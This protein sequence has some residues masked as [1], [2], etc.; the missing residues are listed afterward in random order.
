[1]AVASVQTQS[2]CT[3]SLHCQTEK[4]KRKLVSTQYTKAKSKRNELQKEFLDK[5]FQDSLSQF[6]SRTGQLRDFLNLTKGLLDERVD[7]NN[8]AWQTVLHLG[9]YAACS[10][11]TG[12][13]YNDEYVEFLAL[14]NMLY[15]SSVLN[16][17]RGPGHFGT[18]ISGECEKGKFNPSTS[19]C[20]F[21]V[22]SHNVIQKRCEGY[23]KKIDPGIIES[24]LDICQE[25]ST[26]HG[27]QYN[28]SFD[29]MLIAQGSKGI[30]DGDVNL[31]GIKKPVSISKSQ[32]HLDLELKL[33][34]EL[35]IRITENN[36]G[37]QRY[38]IKRLLF[39]FMKRL[40][41]M[42]TRLTG[43]FLIEQ[44]MEK[45]KE[46]NPD[47]KDAFEHMLSL[48]F[49]NTTQIEN[50]VSRT[51]ATNM[52]ICHL[53][54]EMRGSKCCVNDTK[55]VKLH[56]QPNY[57]GLL[58]SEYVSKHIDLWKRENTSTVCS[59]VIYGGNLEEQP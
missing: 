50:C 32:K 40:Q 55:F 10:S 42:R 5:K 25:L 16:I 14:L 38:K 47:H 6:L 27:K 3:Q 17:L 24:S 29:G 28:L 13:H 48:I 52:D 12:M 33:A 35:E 54:A 44:H 20:N 21:P 41:Q 26:T 34:E 9:R 1:M 31:W 7:S 2:K 39:R 18:V 19:K 51:L 58:P 37:T 23:S 36:L 49:W 11:T 22:P 56:K 4:P 59:T 53:L 45:M 15:G 8:M 46:R 43:D 30:S 57:F